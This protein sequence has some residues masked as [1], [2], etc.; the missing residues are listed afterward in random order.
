M[1]EYEFQK[2]DINDVLDVVMEHAG[3]LSSPLDSFMEE[4]ILDNETYAICDGGM[5]VGYA[6]V[7]RKNLFS[8]YVKKEYYHDAPS[9]LDAFVR[10]FAIEGA[11]VLTHDSLFAGLLMEWDYEVVE[12]DA[13]FFSD[14]GR[15]GRPDVKAADLLFREV[16]MDELEKIN[17]LTDDFFGEHLDEMIAKHTIFVLEDG[18]DALGYGVVEEGRLCPGCVSIGMITRREHRRKG[19]AQRI[20][21]HLKEWAY[22][23]GLRPVAGCWY[24]NVLS[25]K[26]LEA[27]GMI[28]TG[29]K[30]TVRLL[31]KKVLPLRTGNPPGE[32]V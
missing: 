21:W 20:L 13:C 18:G 7:Q 5:C 1:Q 23:R 12:K 14:A 2:R 32:L 26:S 27:A 17:L 6:G 19:V 29:K 3:M 24:Y 15:Q 8:F 10:Q 22:V 25:R 30:F 9:I 4:N 28:A 31:E 16:A 11:H